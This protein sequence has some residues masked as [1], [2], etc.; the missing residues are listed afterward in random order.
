MD[1]WC[2][3][4]ESLTFVL[5]LQEKNGM[6]LKLAKLAAANEMTMSWFGLTLLHHYNWHSHTNTHAQKING[7]MPDREGKSIEVDDNDGL[8]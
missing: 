8:G 4:N 3:L 1:C 2:H 5:S 6:D 7:K